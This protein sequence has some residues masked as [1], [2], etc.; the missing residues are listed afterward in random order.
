MWHVILCL[1]FSCPIF[2]N[3]TSRFINFQLYVTLRWSYGVVVWE[4]FALGTEP[5]LGIT[6][7][8]TIRRVVAGHRMDPPHGTPEQMYVSCDIYPEGPLKSG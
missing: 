7:E 6:P 5:Y 8:E 2:D 1:S 4:I 3:S